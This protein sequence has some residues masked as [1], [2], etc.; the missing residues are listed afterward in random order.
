MSDIIYRSGTRE[1][2]PIL[3]QFEQ[4]IISFE[5]E[6]DKNLKAPCVY[7]DFEGLFSSPDTKIIVAQHHSK[8]I[9]SG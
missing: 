9:G 6:F 5:R 1:D 3:L 7:Y 4:A 2:L 8:L